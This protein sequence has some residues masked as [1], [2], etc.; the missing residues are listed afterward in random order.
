[1]TLAWLSREAARHLLNKTGVFHPINIKGLDG[2][3][4][5][6]QSRQFGEPGR[7]IELVWPYGFAMQLA[8]AR[9]LLIDLLRRESAEYWESEIEDYCLAGIAA[10]RIRQDSEARATY[11]RLHI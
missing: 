4:L 5:S 10:Y 1:M 11:S 9:D 6:C 8:E 2:S 7:T 3:W